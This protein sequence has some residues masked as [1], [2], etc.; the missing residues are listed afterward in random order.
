MQPVSDTPQFIL[1]SRAVL[2]WQLLQ[3]PAHP[4]KDLPLLGGQAGKAPKAESTM[5]MQEPGRPCPSQQPHHCYTPSWHQAL[6]LATVISCAL[7]HQVLKL[8]SDTAHLWLSRPKNNFEGL[9]LEPTW[10]IHCSLLE[11]LTPCLHKVSSDHSKIPEGEQCIIS[12]TL[13][14]VSTLVRPITCWHFLF[15]ISAGT[16]QQRQCGFA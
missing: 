10:A 6:C 12:L 4:P 1:Q 14:A 5:E 2:L 9:E 3:T 8:A 16:K 11:A 7:L 15:L 13:P